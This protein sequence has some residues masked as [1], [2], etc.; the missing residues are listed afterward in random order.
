MARKVETPVVPASNLN[1]ATEALPEDSALKE[2]GF[3]QLTV[4]A[5]ENLIV[6]NPVEAQRYM[7]LYEKLKGYKKEAANR[8]GIIK[9]SI[10]TL[11]QV[12]MKAEQEYR[13]QQACERNSHMR[14]DNRTALVGQ[15]DNNHELLLV[16]QRCQK[17][18]HGVGN[19]AGALPMHLAGTVDMSLIGGVQ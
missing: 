4:A 16:C 10:M 6:Q 19:E 13:N 15:R 9:M 11:K 17:H 7:D 14:E 3:K 18:Y 1:L 8:D 12:Q 2:S 5:L